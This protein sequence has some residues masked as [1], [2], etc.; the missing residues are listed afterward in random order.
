M[1]NE[2]DEIW[3]CEAIPKKLQWKQKLFYAPDE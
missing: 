3:L 2:Y 1:E